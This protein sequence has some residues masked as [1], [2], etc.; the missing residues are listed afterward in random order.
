MRNPIV[1]H[2]EMMDDI[3]YLQ[4][5]LRQHDAK[6]F[7]QAVVKEVNRHV[8]CKNWSLKKTSK[9][10]DD[11]Q[12]I[13]SVLSVQRKRDL[14]TK[15]VKSQKARLNFHGR[16]KIYGMNY[17]KTYAPVVTCFAIRLMIIFGL[18]VWCKPMWVKK[19]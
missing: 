19:S 11:I 8:D 12:I 15:K 3:M 16:K 18:L 6:E 4:Q 13:P 1:F 14:T 10:P 5:A 9:V 17:F 7:V 2:T